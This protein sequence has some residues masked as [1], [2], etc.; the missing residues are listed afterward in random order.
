MRTEDLIKTLAQDTTARPPLWRTAG[1]MAAAGC[2]AALVLFLATLGIRPNLAEA[3]ATGLFQL[4]MTVFVAITI[5]T[6]LDYYRLMRPGARQVP[7]GV[8]AGAAI[9]A[10]VALY[11]LAVVPAEQW[12][13]EV[14]SGNWRVCLM[15]IPV[16]ALCPLAGAM[17]AMRGAA[18]ASPEIAGLAGGGVA[19]AIGATI[20]AMHC[21]ADSPIYYAVWYSIAAIA[22]LAAATVAGRLTLRW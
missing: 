19:A 13:A 11:Q 4:K 7:Y 21:P 17:I 14:F 10:A 22:V 1:L 16:L 18:P 2:A 8:I 5:V 20:Y 3:A 6:A 9:L 12:Q 15:S